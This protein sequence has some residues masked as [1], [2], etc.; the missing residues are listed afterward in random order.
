MMAAERFHF[1]IIMILYSWTFFLLVGIRYALLYKD[2]Q[3]LENDPFA[4]CSHMSH[5]VLIS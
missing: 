2:M 5:F 4:F 1:V 3:I